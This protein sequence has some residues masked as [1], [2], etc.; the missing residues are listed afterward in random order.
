MHRNR[1]QI[2]HHTFLYFRVQ[3]PNGRHFESK[4]SFAS[5]SVLLMFLYERCRFGKYPHVFTHLFLH[6]R[7]SVILHKRK[8]PRIQ[9]WIFF[10]VTRENERYT[11]QLPKLINQNCFLDKQEFC[12]I[13]TIT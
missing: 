12:Y 11:V 4:S 7:K 1:R 9:F 5:I 13:M 8:L 2:K 3:L 10:E 6:L